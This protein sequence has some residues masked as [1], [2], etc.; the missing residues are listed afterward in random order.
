[1][2]VLSRRDHSR[3]ELERKLA[4]AFP[5]QTDLIPDVLNR[6]QEQSYLCDLRF[7]QS[8][9]RYRSGLGF[10]P[11][12]VAQELQAKGVAQSVT[13]SAMLEVEEDDLDWSKIARR[14][15]LKKFNR[16][17]S[18]IKEKSRQIRFL[19]YRGF[20]TEHFACFLKME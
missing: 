1:M 6:L 13:E 8:Y 10:G 18:D 17:P 16:P 3:W 5:E 20:I 12:R 2:A 4:A 9:I 7:A 14:V 15:W 19:M 11:I